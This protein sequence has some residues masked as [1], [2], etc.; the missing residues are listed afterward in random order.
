MARG[1][2]AA[3]AA[4]LL[5]FGLGIGASAPARA[6]ELTTSWYTASGPQQLRCRVV[7]VGKKPATVLVELVDSAGAN[8]ATLTFAGCD[9]EAPLAPHGFCSVLVPG[10]ASAYCRITSSS[11]HVRGAV[12]IEDETS[13]DVLHLVPVTK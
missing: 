11:K 7:N 3:S 2:F 6:V 10:P 9:G 12:S 1:A 4:A 5:S 8:I 13:G